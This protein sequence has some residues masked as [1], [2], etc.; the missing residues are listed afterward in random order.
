MTRMIRYIGCLHEHCT[1]LTHTAS[2]SKRISVQFFA[3]WTWVNFVAATFVLVDFW[4]DGMW[5]VCSFVLVITGQIS[6]GNSE[7]LNEFSGYGPILGHGSGFAY[8]PQLFCH[9]D[10]ANVRPHVFVARCWTL[11]ADALL[12][13]LLL[14]MLRVLQEGPLTDAAKLPPLKFAWKT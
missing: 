5:W 7:L 10:S 4:F 8:V 6:A 14:L 11:T 12:L 1:F 9:T 3:A 2:V 13:L